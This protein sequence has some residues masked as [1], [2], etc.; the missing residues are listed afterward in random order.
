MIDPMDTMVMMKEKLETNVFL[1]EPLYNKMP[2]TLFIMGAIILASA[3]YFRE[4]YS[5]AILYFACG[6]A[7]CMYGA[8]LFMYRKG[9]QK[10]S[11]NSE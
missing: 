11:K 6:M 9:V 5:W 2:M 7:S 10:P 4:F 8:G 3:F 1:P